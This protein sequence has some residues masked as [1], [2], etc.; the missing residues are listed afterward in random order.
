MLGMLPC[1][2]REQAAISSINVIP[3]MTK[4][5]QLFSFNLYPFPTIIILSSLENLSRYRTFPKNVG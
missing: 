5:A 1:S 4:L 2:S 3:K